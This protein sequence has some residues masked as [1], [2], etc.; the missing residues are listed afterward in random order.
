M[1]ESLTQASKQLAIRVPSL[2][3]LSTIA[4][5][6]GL[7]FEKNELVEYRDIIAETLGDTYQRLYEL[8]DPKLP[9]K[10]P[11]TPGY[12][13]SAEENPCNAWYWRCDIKGAPHGKLQG[14]TVAIKDNTAVSGVPMMN[15]SHTL[16]GFVPDVD[17]SV[18]SR[19]LDAGGHIV[20]KAVCED[21]CASGGSFTSV[22]G[23]SIRIPSAACGIVGL[24]PTYGLVPYT[25]IMPI[26]YTLDHT[27]P[28][29]QTVY[30]VALML[31][32]LAGY[33]DGLDPRQPRD[34]QVPEYTKLLTG[35]IENMK[36]GILREGFGFKHSEPDVDRMVKEA[37]ESLGTKCGAVVEEVSVP[38]H[39]DGNGIFAVI[40]QIGGDRMML[41]GAGFGSSTKMYHDTT[42][43]EAAS[44]G[45]K[46]HGN[47]MSKSCK[48]VRLI[49]KY[50]REDYNSV[51]YG[52]AQNL[53]RVLCKAYDEALQKYDVLT[54]APK[55]S[56][57]F[58]Q[59]KPF[60]GRSRAQKV[61]VES[62]YM[63][64][65]KGDSVNC[66]PFNVSG[67]RALTINAGF[68]EGLPVGMMIVGRKFEDASVLNV[69][70]A[71]E[72]IRDNKLFIFP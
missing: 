50:L 29:C 53:G 8:P 57:G 42:L 1:A 64:R 20:G 5:D 18:V 67:H 37:A 48:L 4:G 13:P 41:E 60:F 59:R 68:S 61:G 3:R 31:E 35:K 9:V 10:Y 28:M 38:M 58:P 44:R 27:G 63:D 15:G 34:L 56:T 71:Y 33:D 19:I 39:L 11:R 36:I 47:D 12:R 51:F 40:F 62:K 24:K 72:E 54:D 23:G 32:V 26:E 43:Q 52:K 25:G 66:S 49:A 6:L 45:I 7:D 21:L 2:Q 14:K 16:E 22:T 70:Y 30:E 55:E 65:A 69:A 17:A 46:C